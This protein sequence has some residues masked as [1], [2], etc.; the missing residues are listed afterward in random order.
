MWYW[1]KVIDKLTMLQYMDVVQNAILI[2][3]NAILLV[4]LLPIRCQWLEHYLQ[5]CSFNCV[6][7]LILHFTIYNVSKMKLKSLMNHVLPTI[8]SLKA[9]AHW[10]MT[11]NMFDYCFHTCNC[12]LLLILHT[13]LNNTLNELY[14]IRGYDR[15]V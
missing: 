7:H 4:G 1:Q 3:V 14:L 2:N 9:F 13:S 5:L 6:Q 11:N 15:S 12:S 10:W 8:V